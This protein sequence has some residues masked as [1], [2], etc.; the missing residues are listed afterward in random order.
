[1]CVVTT[2]PTTLKALTA[3]DSYLVN[4]LT[5]DIMEINHGIVDMC[6]VY[7]QSIYSLS[8]QEDHDHIQ[9]YAIYGDSYHHT[10]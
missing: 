7:I 6:I 9:R 5:V 3:P 1:M 4:G 10:Y 8:M 2:I